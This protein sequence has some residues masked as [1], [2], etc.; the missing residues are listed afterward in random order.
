MA[1]RPFTADDRA[2]GAATEPEQALA[3]AGRHQLNVIAADMADV[4]RLT[5]G[6]LYDQARAGWAVNVLVAT[7]D[8]MRDMRPLAILG[9]TALAGDARSVLANAPRDGA[10]A[11][12]ADLLRADTQLREHVLKLAKR[13]L[14]EVKVW[15]DGCPDALGRKVKPV[16]HRL[17]AAA[18]AF[19]GHALIAAAV[20]QDVVGPTE[21]LFLV[22][23]EP[24]RPLHSV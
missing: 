3:G 24:V 1:T 15:G 20:S 7:S 11:V 12:S 17:S 9:A 5:G 13:G 4:V 18:R 21:T 8:S 22:G 10:L 16:Q 2:F 19:K 6:W 14:T 23:T